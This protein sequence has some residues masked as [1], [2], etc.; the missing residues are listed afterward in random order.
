[1][2]VV[3][4]CQDDLASRPQISAVQSGAAT[5]TPTI[6]PPLAWPCRTADQSHLQMTSS[7]GLLLTVA[8]SLEGEVG[9]VVVILLVVVRGGLGLRGLGF[10]PRSPLLRGFPE[11]KMSLT[12]RR[13]HSHSSTIGATFRFWTECPK[14]HEGS[15]NQILS[16]FHSLWGYTA[17]SLQLFFLR[18]DSKL[19]KSL[20]SS[21][22][23]LQT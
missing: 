11:G 15:K 4:I 21:R 17:C 23:L 18:P 7:Q 19:P 12:I 2:W 8:L 10:W 6:A 1:M 3:V 13:G 20:K 16:P 9:L 22:N 5:V 14:P